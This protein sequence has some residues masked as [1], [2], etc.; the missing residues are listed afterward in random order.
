[1]SS[2]LSS[3]VTALWYELADRPHER[4]CAASPEDEPRA[5]E[6]GR[7]KSGERGVGEGQGDAETGLNLAQG[8]SRSARRVPMQGKYESTHTIR[9]RPRT[10]N[11]T[12]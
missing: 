12:P 1:M 5:P 8:P 4:A 2:A 7:A 10:K 6:V 11:E 3:A 9:H